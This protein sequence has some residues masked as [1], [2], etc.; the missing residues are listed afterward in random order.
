MQ[1]T[2][3]CKRTKQRWKGNAGEE[4]ELRDM[5]ANFC[6]WI[7]GQTNCTKEK[8]KTLT[9]KIQTFEQNGYLMILRNYYQYS[10]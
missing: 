4:E 9:F 10:R 8:N 5:T 2:K 7:L 3:T 1:S 6:A